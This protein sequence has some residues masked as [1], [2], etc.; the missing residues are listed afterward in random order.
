VFKY[1]TVYLILTAVK[2]F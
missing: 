2:R 1:L